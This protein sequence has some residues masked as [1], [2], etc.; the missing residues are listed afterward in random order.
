MVSGY[1]LGEYRNFGRELLG[2][3]YISV[4]LLVGVVAFLLFPPLYLLYH[5]V[6]TG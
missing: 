1:E 3:F 6:Y 5:S 2:G 4:L